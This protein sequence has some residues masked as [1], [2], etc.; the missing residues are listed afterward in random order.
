MIASPIDKS[1]INSVLLFTFYRQVL[2]IRNPFIDSS[3]NFGAKEKRKYM[4]PDQYK[5]AIRRNIQV[6]LNKLDSI[7]DSRLMLY[8]YLNFL[9]STR[10]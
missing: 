1:N 6:S 10:M 8:T 5:E 7:V 9:T 2:L 3:G 4:V